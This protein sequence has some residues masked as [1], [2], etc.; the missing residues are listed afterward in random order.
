MFGMRGAKGLVV[1]LVGCVRKELR[2]TRRKWV[3]GVGSTRAE[4]T[5]T[6]RSGPAL[7]TTI[8]SHPIV[9]R[10]GS[11]YVSAVCVVWYFSMNKR[12]FFTNLASSSEGLFSF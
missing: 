10:D 2:V 5:T 4:R 11:N 8:P 12:E 1:R 6:T 7:L 3:K 9:S